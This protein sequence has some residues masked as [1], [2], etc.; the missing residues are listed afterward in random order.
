MN[1]NCNVIFPQAT[2][3]GEVLGLMKDAHKKLKRLGCF[4]RVD[5]IIDTVNEE[6]GKNT[7]Y[8]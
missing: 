8:Q 5:G 3:Y 7:D 1:T 2:N 4:K 6:S